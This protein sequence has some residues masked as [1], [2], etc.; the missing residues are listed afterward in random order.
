MIPVSEWRVNAID[1]YF[2]LIFQ[3]DMEIQRSKVDISGKDIKI[4]RKVHT[5]IY[6]EESH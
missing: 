3:T 5:Q 4:G 6:K 2:C 1:V